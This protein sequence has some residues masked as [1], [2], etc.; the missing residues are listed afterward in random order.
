[1]PKTLKTDPSVWTKV[2]RR[3]VTQITTDPDIRRVVGEDNVRS[4]K[5]VPADKAPFEPSTGQPVVCLTPQPRNVQWY[6][7]DKMVGDLVVHVQIAVSSLCLDDVTDLWDLFPAALS[8]MALDAQG[9]SFALDL[10]ALGAET[11][12]IVFTDPA[13]DPRPAAEP[14]GQFF[15][16]GSFT[17]RVLRPV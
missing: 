5:G 13:F 3:I 16:T 7:P 4:W 8:P 12:D 15:A 14:E 2:F 6:S 10:V 17:L 9:N 1:V 11:G